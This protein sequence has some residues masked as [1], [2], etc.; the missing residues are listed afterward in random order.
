MS[1]YD[2]QPIDGSPPP[3]SV[4]RGPGRPRIL[5]RG[6]PGPTPAPFAPN[7]QALSLPTHLSDEGFV[8]GLTLTITNPRQDG[9]KEIVD[10]GDL[11]S[12]SLAYIV[13]NAKPVYRKEFTERVN[14]I[15]FDDNRRKRDKGEMDKEG[16]KRARE[17][18][19]SRRIDEKYQTVNNF[20]SLLL[21]F[22]CVMRV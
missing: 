1:E 11:M 12:M 15:L 3:D 6:G 14:S 18:G 4:R 10:M 8:T 7:N 2:T 16:R 17:I 9:F 5:D 22:T 21:V 13:N 19:D 20:T